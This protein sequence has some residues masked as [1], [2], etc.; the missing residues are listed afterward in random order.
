[1]N[2]NGNECYITTSASVKNN[3]NKDALYMLLY[4]G[5][6]RSQKFSQHNRSFPIK[7]LSLY[8]ENDR[9]CED[10][11]KKVNGQNNYNIKK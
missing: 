10:W 7:I 9:F 5:F 11:F 4:K 1:M 3:I 8:K 2:N 6:H